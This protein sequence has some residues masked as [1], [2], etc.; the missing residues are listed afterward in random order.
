MCESRAVHFF[1]PIAMIKLKIPMITSMSWQKS[2]KVKYI[3]YRPLSTMGVRARRIT[4]RVMNTEGNRHPYGK[5]YPAIVLELA[6]FV[7]L[8]TLIFVFGYAGQ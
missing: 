7:N 3:G 4:L 2:F 8:W 5:P 6:D 1:F